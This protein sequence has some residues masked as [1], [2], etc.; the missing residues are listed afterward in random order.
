MILNGSPWKRGTLLFILSYVWF[1]LNIRFFKIK[2]NT[3]SGKNLENTE[4]ASWLGKESSGILPSR[5]NFQHYDV[6]M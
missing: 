1:I 2:S 6:K 3:Y 4:K 5:N